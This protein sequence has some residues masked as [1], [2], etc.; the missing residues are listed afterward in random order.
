MRCVAAQ[1]LDV[2]A[3][4]AQ[5]PDEIGDG[6]AV[7][8]QL[9]GW[10]KVG[11][12]QQVHASVPLSQLITCWASTPC[13]HSWVSARQPSL[14]KRFSLQRLQLELLTVRVRLELRGSQSL[15]RACAYSLRH[16]CPRPPAWVF[17]RLPLHALALHPRSP[18]PGP[19]DMHPLAE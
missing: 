10:V 11:D 17:Q 14:P 9:L 3:S 2:V 8:T 15:D 1:H 6:A 19:Y 16:R 13:M 7:P 5:A 12:H 18:Q 4:F